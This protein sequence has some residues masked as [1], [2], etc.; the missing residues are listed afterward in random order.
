[1]R[2]RPG[3]IEALF[4]DTDLNDRVDIIYMPLLLAQLDDGRIFLE[5]VKDIYHK[6]TGG[7]AAVRGLAQANGIESQI[8][9]TR[10][11][12]AVNDAEGIA[13]DVSFH[14]EHVSVSEKPIRLATNNKMPADVAVES[15]MPD[16]HCRDLAPRDVP[17]ADEGPTRCRLLPDVKVETPG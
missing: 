2:L 8:D 14:S 1:M 4:N 17:A 16:F 11:E 15:L 10:A 5:S 6:G 7:I 12:E 3:D 13:R 9:W